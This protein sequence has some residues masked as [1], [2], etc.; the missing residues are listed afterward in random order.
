MKQFLTGFTTFS[1]LLLT[2]ISN[3]QQVQVTLANASDLRMDSVIVNDRYVGTLNASSDTTIFYKELRTDTSYPTVKANAQILGGLRISTPEL[4][5][6]CGTMIRIETD[7]TYKLNL[8][9]LQNTT[10]PY[11]YVEYI[12]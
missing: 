6:E 1:L 8:K 4:L 7:G 5:P 9:V 10:G 11:L 12:Q 3:A 2:F